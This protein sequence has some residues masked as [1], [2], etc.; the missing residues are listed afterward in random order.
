MPTLTLTDESFFAVVASAEQ[1]VLVD[2]WAQWCGPCKMLAPALEQLADDYSGRLVIGK[3]NIDEHPETPAKCGVRG[4]PSLMLF[5]D[6][7]VVASKSGAMQMSA[8][9]T[10]I[11]QCL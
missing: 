1:P 6:G 4:I 5:K 7:A 10:W 11:D 9:K 2:F 8:L 3:L